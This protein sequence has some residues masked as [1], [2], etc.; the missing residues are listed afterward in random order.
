MKSEMK[1]RE[2]DA[3]VVSDTYNMAHLTGYTANAG[4]VPQALVVSL[5]EEPTF[6]PRRQEAPAAIHQTFMD[7]SKIVGYREAHSSVIRTWMAT[8]R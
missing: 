3:L 6:I 2:I 1:R 5:E 8:T 7:R 4:Y